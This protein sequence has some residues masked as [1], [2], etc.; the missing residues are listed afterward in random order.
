MTENHSSHILF[1]AVEL[2]RESQD[3]AAQADAQL[4][5]SLSKIKYTR[6]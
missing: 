3:G 5:P 1:I 6:T 4:A 2:S